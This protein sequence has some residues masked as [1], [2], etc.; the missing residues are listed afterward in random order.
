MKKIYSGFILLSTLLLQSSIINAQNVG[1]NA[2][3]AAPSADAMLDISATDK[4]LLVPRVSIAN[5]ATIAPITGGTTTGLLVYNTNATTGAGY[6]Y[7]DGTQWVR[8]F[9]GDAWSL[10]GNAGTV[11]GTNFLGTTDNVD[12]SIRRNNLETM[13]VLATTTSFRDEI[14]TRDGGANSGDVLVRIYDSSDDGIVDIYENNAYNIRLH[15]N[16]TTIF[17]EQGI[18]TN[19][20]RIESDNN[21]NM[22]F[23]DASL[24]NIGM[25]VAPNANNNILTVQQAAT[26]GT[27]GW[28]NTTANSTWVTL[29]ASATSTTQGTGVSGLGFTGVS[30]NTTSAGGWAGFFNYDT[31]IDWMFY[32]GAT[33]VSDARLKSDINEINDAM[34]ILN[35]LNPVKYNKASGAFQQNILMNGKPYQREESK[36]QEYGFLAQDVEKVLP[37]LVKSK[38]M[39]MTSGETMDVKGVNYTMLIPVLTK[40]LQEQQAIIESQNERIEKLEAQI[41]ELIEHK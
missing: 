12:F 31:Y 8:F 30:G 41:K 37:H 15:G 19:D 11:A 32:T 20:F 13:R 17:N 22:F 40:G 7:W 4:G 34:V 27:A 2:T 26:A 36:I 25:A 21:Q 33:L 18:A 24:N 1:I 35:S 10:T 14:Q 39:N 9:T 38:K 29:E 5:L 16:G 23:M 3:G 6:Y 28:F